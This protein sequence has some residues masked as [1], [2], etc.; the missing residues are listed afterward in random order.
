[1]NLNIIQLSISVR[2][3]QYAVQF[4]CPG[5]P[6]HAG[7]VAQITATSVVVIDDLHIREA[8]LHTFGRL[9][10]RNCVQGAVS[11]NDRP[12]VRVIV[13][14]LVQFSNIQG[15]AITGGSKRRNILEGNGIQQLA[16]APICIICFLHLNIVNQAIRLTAIG[17]IVH[18]YFNFGASCRII[19]DPTAEIIVIRYRNR[20]FALSMIVIG[21]VCIVVTQVHL[22]SPHRDLHRI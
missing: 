17:Y 22:S 4:F 19:A 3:Q 2:I 10:N 9:G 1:M 20:L 16:A 6:V 11:S 14:G 7:I 21:Q 13:S 8:K 18:R 12:T 5:Q 15:R